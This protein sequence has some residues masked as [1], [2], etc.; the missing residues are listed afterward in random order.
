M[1]GANAGELLIAGLPAM[2][3]E[4]SGH[5]ETRP[6]EC[7]SAFRKVLLL[8]VCLFAGERIIYCGAILPFIAILFPELLFRSTYRIRRGVFERT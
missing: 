5:Y 3:K 7:S 1:R 4:V 2:D 6:C 8:R